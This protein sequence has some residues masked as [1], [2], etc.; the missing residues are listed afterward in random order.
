[1][2]PEL[3]SG[4]GVGSASCALRCC[5]RSAARATLYACMTLCRQSRQIRSCSL[6][7]WGGQPSAWMLPEYMLFD[8]M[9][10]SFD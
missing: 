6:R 8:S 4:D 3:L 10:R 7:R 5:R 2:H 9:Q 1:M